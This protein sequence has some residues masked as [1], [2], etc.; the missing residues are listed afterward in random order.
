MLLVRMQICL[1]DSSD[2]TNYGAN[3]LKLFV[4]KKNSANMQ[5]DREKKTSLAD[6][7]EDADDNLFKVF[8]TIMNMS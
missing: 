7:V 8:Y 3:I 2:W 5:K 1:A 6:L 4:I